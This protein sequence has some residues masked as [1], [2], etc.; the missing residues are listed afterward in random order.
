MLEDN[1]KSYKNFILGSVGSLLLVFGITLILIFWKDV[2]S[3]F[4][5][6]LGIIMA[7]AGLAVIYFVQKK[8]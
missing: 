4:R 8:N 6:M 7:V 2:I 5:G 1:N 3:L